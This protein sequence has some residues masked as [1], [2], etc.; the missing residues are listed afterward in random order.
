MQQRLIPARAFPPG[1]ILQKELE[2]RGWTDRDLA[3]IDEDLPQTIA[4]I[5][6]GQHHITPEIAEKLSKAF[7]TSAQSWINLENNYRLYLAKKAV[8]QVTETANP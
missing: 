7:G 5:I 6:Q 8:E 3:A 2:A 1:R 4:S